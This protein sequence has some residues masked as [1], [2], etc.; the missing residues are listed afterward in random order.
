MARIDDPK[1]NQAR[2]LKR[3]QRTLAAQ[4]PLGNS[5]V[6]EGAL[7]VRSAEGLKVEGSATVAGILYGDG[8]FTW[9]G[10]ASFAGSVD[11]TGNLDVLGGGS[12]TAGPIYMTPTGTFGG[13]IGSTSWLSLAS[14]SG[15]LVLAPMTTVAVDV[16]STLKVQGPITNSGITTIALAGHTPNVWCDPATGRFYRTV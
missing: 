2:S 5:S 4:S 13:T 7:V 16:T 12:I 15:V 1:A 14:T 3:G 8:T 6:S 11:L 10:P 9:I